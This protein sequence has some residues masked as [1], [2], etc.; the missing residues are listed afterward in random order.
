MGVLVAWSTLSIGSTA[1]AERLNCPEGVVYDF[2]L[3]D[4]RPSDEADDAWSATLHRAQGTR[5][6][7]LPK[8]SIRRGAL[9]CEYELPNG[10]F[11]IAQRSPPDGTECRIDQDHPLSI[12]HFFCE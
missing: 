6:T 12:P 2:A 1:L 7:R 4:G 3:T 10:G 8:L 9:R 11:T 5:M